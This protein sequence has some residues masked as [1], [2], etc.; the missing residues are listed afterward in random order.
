MS[1]LTRRTLL[2]DSGRRGASLLGNID[3]QMH[4]AQ[5]NSQIRVSSFTRPFTSHHL[6][7]TGYKYRLPLVQCYILPLSPLCS[8]TR[9]TE[10]ESCSDVLLAI[11]K[12]LLPQQQLPGVTVAS[13]RHV[14]LVH[15]LRRQKEEEA[16]ATNSEH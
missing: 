10:Q 3:R 14:E 13:G 5:S 12:S 6:S 2:T 9:A 16:M 15:F 11:L 1:V 4:E 7:N 8:L